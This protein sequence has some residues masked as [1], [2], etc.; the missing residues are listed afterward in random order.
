MGL[1]DLFHRRNK[2]SHDDSKK[3][4]K[5]SG[6]ST[7][8]SPRR[9]S[10][11]SVPYETTSPSRAPVIGRSPLH[12]DQAERR[13]GSPLA[14]TA[15][16]SRLSQGNERS[17]RQSGY[18]SEI[19]SNG[20]PQT[21]STE[22]ENGMQQMN[23][24]GSSSPPKFNR[25]QPPQVPPHTSP[26]PLFDQGDLYSEDVADANIARNET[27]HAITTDAPYNT[28]KETPHAI[29]RDAPAPLNFSNGP[30]H[31]H[32]T[33]TASSGGPPSSAYDS[34]TSPSFSRLPH[35]SSISRKPLDEDA[36]IA[37]VS[38]AVAREAQANQL[39]V[40][41]TPVVRRRPSKE[42]LSAN[43]DNREMPP[44]IHVDGGAGS[45]MLVENAPTAPSLEGVVDL[46]NTVDTAIE[47]KW[48]PA[49]T[50]TVVNKHHHHIRE[51]VITRQIHNHEVYH[52]ILPIIDIQVLPA[53]HF[54]LHPT[55][56]E[57]I[58]ISEDQVPGRTRDHVNWVIA[59]TV[60][61]MTPPDGRLNA[62]MSRFT[63]RQFGPEEGETRHWIEKDGTRKSERTW[64]HPPELDHGA[65][66]SGQSV[67]FHFGHPNEEMNGIRL[68]LS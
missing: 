30:R 32:T 26:K 20:R 50:H 52:R 42:D 38:P 25:D 40:L 16:T 60:T 48:A 7:P 11:D 46:S 10:T 33:S 28:T 6:Q 43:I 24:Q 62:H 68:D 9:D 57:K 56:G 17:V 59:E 1:G 14:N 58:E 63:A 51:E 15:D 66:L 12:G 4:R 49:V 18:P 3:Q 55:T 27:P 2:S 67:P 13:P 36:Q 44:P 41:P 64:V 65:H 35:R 37:A 54:V 39:D 61:K 31:A 22:L 45:S 5:S 23:L 8:G 29:T 47:E 19:G 21:D 53:R 34:A